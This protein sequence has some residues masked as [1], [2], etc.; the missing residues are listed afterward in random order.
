M[1]SRVRRYIN[2]SMETSRHSDLNESVIRGIDEQDAAND[3][4]IDEQ[5]VEMDRR[6]AE[7]DERHRQLEI[8]LGRPIPMRRHRASRL[9]HIPHTPHPPRYY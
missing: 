5:N 6:E 3:R 1:T 8:E 9:P 4:F 2:Y 7:A